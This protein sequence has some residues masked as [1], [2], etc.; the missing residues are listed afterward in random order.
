MNTVEA[1]YNGYMKLATIR[2]ARGLSQSELAELAHVEQPTISR[3][4]R[5]Y[6]G[7]T[8]RILRQLAVALD[9]SV[10]DLLS[11]ER[12]AAEDALLK[13]FRSLPAER[14]QGWTDMAMAFAQDPSKPI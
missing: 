4:E 5:G 8:L 14:Q 6:D 11:D 2:K 9:I 13:A 1:S 3:I 12:T 7:V 10:H